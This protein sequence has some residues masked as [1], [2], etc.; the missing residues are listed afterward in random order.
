MK[1]VV[2]LD[3]T[4]M[5]FTF[6]DRVSLFGTQLKGLYRF[7]PVALSALKVTLLFKDR[8]QC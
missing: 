2:A 6:D 3:S 7:T 8:S 5:S 1:C 4:E